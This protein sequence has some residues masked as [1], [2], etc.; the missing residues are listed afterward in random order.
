[1]RTVTIR[2]TQPQADFY[3]LTCKH[4]AFIAGFGTGKSETMANQAFMDASHS[5]TA[6]IGLYEP[7]YD[8]VR[9]IMAPRM[10][11]KL[12]EYGIRYKYNKSEN[13][14]YTSH[15]NFGD[16]ILRTLDNPSRIIGYETYRA[17]VDE[18]D[19]LK[20]E[21]A[22]ECWNKIIARNRQTPKGIDKPFNRVSAYSTPEGF[23]FV[24][25]Y[26]KKKPRAGYQ[27][28]QASTL[29]N[30]FL[31]DDYVETLK[32]TYPPQL[33]AAYIEGK[34]TNLTIG[35]IYTCYDRKL[36]DT[37]RV[38]EEHDH[39]HIG[40]DFNVGKMSAIV[41]VEDNVNI[42]DLI[43]EKNL[44]ANK[45]N[46]GSREN[47]KI[48]S[49]VYEFLGLLDTP[50]MIKAIQNKY[51]D[52]RITIYPDASGKNRKSNNASET[53]ISL[54]KKEFRVVNY[55][56]NPFVK[57]RIASVQGLLCNANQLRRYY[58]SEVNCPETCESLE[59]Q[60]YN[61]QG[62]PDKKHDAD[63]PND[64][65]GYYINSQ[66]GIKNNR[67]TTQILIA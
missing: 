17:H 43:D 16:F 37:S 59:Q 46:Y 38:A 31:P 34:F 67:T 47:I 66:F 49:A 8:L 52:R 22:I 64:A 4:P 61:N 25:K 21:K 57:D 33:I 27:M 23:K 18:I 19:T 2:P 48:T 50:E 39:L 26:W 45:E 51:P 30:P 6:L 3:S 28:I 53:D 54:L 14:I 29:S 12:Q 63:H 7:T 56:C 35:T 58:I 15:G 5:S 13:I 36:N 40:M 62:E 24:Y 41:H 10:E 65:L 20:E 32:N 9:L 42:H 44:S 11:E 1:M 55:S 60:V